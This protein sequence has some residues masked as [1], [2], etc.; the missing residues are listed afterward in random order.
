MKKKILFAVFAVMTFVACSSDDDGDSGAPGVQSGTI[1]GDD[2]EAN[3]AVADLRIVSVGD[4][5]F[6]YDDNG[7]LETI[8]DRYGDL[9]LSAKDNF[10]IEEID[11]NGAETV[12]FGIS[13][14]HITSFTDKWSWKETWRENEVS[15]TGNSTANVTYN[16]K[17]QLSS[18]KLSAKEEVVRKEDGK[19]NRYTETG[20]GTVKFTYASDHRITKIEYKEK[21]VD[22]DGK[23]T[24]EET[25]EYVYNQEVPNLFYQYT[26]RLVDCV[27]IGGEGKD[28][29]AY[30]GL[31]GKASSYIPSYCVVKWYESY[32]DDGEYVE[33]SDEYQMNFSCRFNGNG[34]ISYA[35]GSNYTYT[36]IDTRAVFAPTEEQS[37]TTKD[38]KKPRHCLLK[39]LSERRQ[40]RHGK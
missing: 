7:K 19:T 3:A 31:L 28:A 25:Y 27:D 18:V 32:Y 6:A 20:E 9:Y 5:R 17:G 14:N 10:K 36:S 30:V 2:A 13:S 8:S 21:G 34:T 39:R 11:E 35:D 24:Y 23:F 40:Q 4:Y 38:G 12:T 29:F 1:A 33:E 16:S 15:M 26:P 22:V 37:V